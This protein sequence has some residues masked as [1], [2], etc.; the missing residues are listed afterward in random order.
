LKQV[1]VFHCPEWFQESGQE[2]LAL[3]Y[4][5]NAFRSD[6]YTEGYEDVRPPSR[7]SVWR[8]PGRTIYLADM[9]RL[10]EVRA[11]TNNGVYRASSEK[12][13]SPLDAFHPEHLPSATPATRRLARALHLKRKT[14]SLFVDGHTEGVESL[15]FTKEA[16]YDVS[17]TYAQ[18]WLRH[19]GV[20]VP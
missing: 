10:S 12:S 14:N 13:L 1:E 16:Q 4:I 11:D 6:G 9:E 3:S 2:A 8:Y 15:P 19:F 18:R 20:E 17:G 7:V 5:V